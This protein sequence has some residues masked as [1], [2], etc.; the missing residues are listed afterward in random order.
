[1][2]AEVMKT[3]QLGNIHVHLI[4]S[5]K[6]KT[7]T[8]EIFI[9]GKLERST[10]T[11]RV[12]LPRILREG[13]RHYPSHQALQDCLDDLYGAALQLGGWKAGSFQ[14]MNLHFEAANERFVP[15]GAGL[16]EDSLSLVHQVLFA[17]LTE[18]AGFKRTTVEKEKEAVRRQIQAVKDDQMS[19]ANQRLIEEMAGDEPYGIRGAGYEEDLP[20]I[21]P[22]NL[23]E[24]YQKILVED[25]IDLF[26]VGDFESEEM[27]QEIQSV[28]AERQHSGKSKVVFEENQIRKKVEKTKLIVERTKLQQAKLHVGFRTQTLSSDED[29]PVLLVYTMMLGGYTGSK[30]FTEIR[31]KNSL[32]YY[33]QA[34]A[35]PF[36]DKLIVYS[37]IAPGDYEKTERILDEQFERMRKGDFTEQ[38]IEQAKAILISGYLQTQDAATGMIDLYFQQ[39]I[40]GMKFTPE[41]LMEAIQAVT[42]QAI[43]QMA[44]KIEKDT[45]FLLTE[46]EDEAE[47]KK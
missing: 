14:V 15:D 43:I 16:T 7:V 37:G 25:R 47:W 41:E 23:Y 38:E 20:K 31:E 33:V 42:P 17:P 4:P 26:V 11:K 39:T 13:S 19:F 44:E 3:Q 10:V 9:T 2:T 45:T 24:Y 34:A 35:D 6:F 1:M 46:K 27:W 5:K 30:L 22:Q 36:S 21:T 12:L 18:E 28:F 32:A 40:G 29:Y 8:T